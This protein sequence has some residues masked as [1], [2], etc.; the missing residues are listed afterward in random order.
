[1]HS[2]TTFLV[3]TWNGL[4]PPYLTE[5]AVSGISYLF[6]SPLFA[7]FSPYIQVFL[8]FFRAQRPIVYTLVYFGVANAKRGYNSSRGTLLEKTPLH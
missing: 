6:I 7:F 3:V 4:W 1:M 2:A 8:L 5:P